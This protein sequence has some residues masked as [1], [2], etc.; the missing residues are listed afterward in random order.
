MHFTVD[1]NGDFRI[2]IVNEDE[3][4]NALGT[5]SDDQNLEF[6]SFNASGLLK[7][8]T[9]GT[10]F[11]RTV[12]PFD[13][14]EMSETIDESI[15][16][17]DKEFGSID[18]NGKIT[19]NKEAIENFYT[20]NPDGQAVLTSFADGSNKYGNWMAYGKEVL[21]DDGTVSYS[22]Q[23]DNFTDEGLQ[24]AILEGYLSDLPDA[25]SP[26]ASKPPK[27][28][29]E[30]IKEEVVEPTEV[31]EEEVVEPTEVAEEEIETETVTYPGGHLTKAEIDNRDEDDV[32]EALTKYGEHFNITK[33]T[34]MVD[35]I[36]VQSK[37]DRDKYIYVDLNSPYNR[38]KSA[39]KYHN[40]DGDAIYNKIIDF[41]KE[42]SPKAKP[43]D[44]AKS[45]TSSTGIGGK[46][47]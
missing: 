12:E 28:N 40:M 32:A 1:D 10:P 17:G 35:S 13:Y 36:K 20:T 5:M 34:A 15:R 7:S 47:N 18:K 41:I 42:N 25:P 46:Y 11:F 45:T 8:A 19:Y 39:A 16:K 44:K 31:V 29:E 38:K 22:N 21:N 43:S 14:T 26:V 37:T 23:V 24:A 30:V 3:L 9:E 33:P 6:T 27:P 4:N 2:S